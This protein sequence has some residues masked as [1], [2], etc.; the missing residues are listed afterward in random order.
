[1]CYVIQFAGERLETRHSTRAGCS[2]FIVVELVQ[3]IKQRQLVILVNYDTIFDNI[4]FLLLF[5]FAI[6]AAEN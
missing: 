1:M 3:V 2:E 5:S 6:I 4:C